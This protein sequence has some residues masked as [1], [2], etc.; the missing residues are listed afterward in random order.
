[1]Y[2]QQDPD[3]TL[4]QYLFSQNNLYD[5]FRIEETVKFIEKRTDIQDIDVLEV[6]CGGGIWTVYFAQR[7]K[8][9]TVVDTN[10]YLLEATKLYVKQNGFCQKYLFI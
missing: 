4:S 9:V 7:A 1:M 3:Q 5:K 10:E 6:G 2:E 8:I